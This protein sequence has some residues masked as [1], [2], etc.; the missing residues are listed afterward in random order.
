LKQAENKPKTLRVI[1]QKAEHIKAHILK[2]YV[3]KRAVLAGV[4]TAPDPEHFR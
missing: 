1:N 3:K 2:H 4:S